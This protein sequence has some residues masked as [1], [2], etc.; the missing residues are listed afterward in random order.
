MLWWRQWGWGLSWDVFNQ[1][2]DFQGT[3]DVKKETMLHIL[4]LLVLPC[5]IWTA[6]AKGRRSREKGVPPFHCLREGHCS[7]LEV[8][9]L[10]ALV[11]LNCISV[12]YIFVKMWRCLR[13]CAKCCDGR[14]EEEED[15]LRQ[16]ES[17]TTEGLSSRGELSSNQWYDHSW[18]LVALPPWLWR[19]EWGGKTV[20]IKHQVQVEDFQATDNVIDKKQ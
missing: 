18:H 2:E 12:V 13:D 17:S 8:F 15:K 4:S 20:W 19:G 6:K 3:G 11:T 5:L 7:G 1:E 14:R 16:L 10:H 9:I